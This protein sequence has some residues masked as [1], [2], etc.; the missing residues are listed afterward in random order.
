MRQ[1]SKIVFINSANIRYGEVGL[2]REA[3]QEQDACAF[4]QE[5]FEWMLFGIHVYKDSRI[6]LN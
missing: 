6:M 3:P 2:G 4:R 5:R 1:L